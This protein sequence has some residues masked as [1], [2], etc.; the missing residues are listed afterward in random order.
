MT[1]VQTCALPIYDCTVIGQFCCLSF[2]RQSLLTTAITDI[3]NRTLPNSK[4]RKRE[5]PVLKL[6]PTFAPLER[7][8]F[9]TKLTDANLIALSRHLN[10]NCTHSWHAYLEMSASLLLELL[11]ANPGL[12]THLTHFQLS[13]LSNIKVLHLLCQHATELRHLEVT[14]YYGVWILFCNISPQA[15]G[16]N[17]YSFCSI[18]LLI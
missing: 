14:L 17:I 7:F 10:P 8:H 1:G 11:P 15:P 4:A 3:C 16:I 6:L 5:M 9:K 18:R 13:S 2:G 12:F